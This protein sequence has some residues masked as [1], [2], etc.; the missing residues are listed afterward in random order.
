MKRQKKWVKGMLFVIASV[1]LITGCSS[2]SGT[3]GSTDTGKKGD[4][5][6]LRFSWWGGQERHEAT[7][8]AID[9]YKE[10]EPNVKI[11]AEYQG[12]DGY[13]QKVK[14]QLT[15]VTSA[16]IMQLDVPWMKELTRSDNFLDLR[17]QSG[18]SLDGFDDD[19]LNN[20]SVYNDKLVALPTG[21][22]AYAMVINKT[23]AERLGIPTDIQWDW[24]TIYE[25]GKKLHAADNSKH[26]LFADHGMLIMDLTNMLK[27]RTGSQ[28]I[29][30]DYTLGFTQED[31]ESALS[32]MDKSMKDGVYQPLGEADLFYGKTE[33]NLKWINEDI[34][35]I[36]AMSS[37]LISLRNVLP[38]G[39]E[40]TTALPVI[41]KD[42][43]DTAVL[44]R[45][46]QL[47]AVSSKSKHPEE[48]VKFLN[49]LMND[50][51]AA[52]L[53]GDVRSVP[54]S[55][56]AQKAAVEAG[57]IDPTITRAVEM[58][59]ENAGMV[60]NALS[61]NSEVLAIVTDVIEKVAYGRLTPESGAE[62]LVKSLESKLEE[63]KGRQ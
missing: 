30:E 60:D 29:K 23:A 16:D 49:W 4:Q 32:W 31:A 45:P 54:A 38:E 25:E 34:P 37:T 18:L 3:E 14:T 40:V 52:A 41:D 24:D 61:T 1:M 28:W 63:L 39:S 50:G 46:S 13:E 48:A 20:F 56:H 62:E 17:N 11:E 8:A 58:G 10:I 55:S 12:Y 15:S 22:N 59:L 33:Q 2:G 36:S 42:A 47:F 35:M 43:K 44:V 26:L 19:F 9:A 6:T 7:L 57:K 51:E 27:Q 5:V 53:L 21:V